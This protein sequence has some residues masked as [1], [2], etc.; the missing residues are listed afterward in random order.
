MLLKDFL[1][2]LKGQK[3]TIKKRK[4]V[5]TVL[6]FR[7]IF[8]TTSLLLYSNHLQRGQIDEDVPVQSARS[9][10]SVVQDV[11]PVSGSQDDDVVRGTHSCGGERG[12]FKA[13]SDQWSTSGNKRRREAEAHRP[14][15]PAAGL[16]FAPPRCWRNPTCS[17]SASFPQRRSRRC[18]RCRALGS[19]PL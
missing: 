12:G 15:P 18:R 2:L 4:K 13:R 1:P 9:H 14:S 16:A 10:Q 17:W 6:S 3:V 7:Y 11:R 5:P 19:E 8:P